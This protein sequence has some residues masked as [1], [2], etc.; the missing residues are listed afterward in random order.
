MLLCDACRPDVNQHYL[1]YACRANHTCASS[2][3]CVVDPAFDFDFAPTSN[4]TC[5]RRELYHS[6]SLA[7]ENAAAVS[8]GLDAPQIRHRYGCEICLHKSLF[9]LNQR[10]M[11]GGSLLLL[12]GALSG[13]VGI[14][15]GGLNIPV[16]VIVMG[17]HV[18]EVRR[19][20]EQAPREDAVRA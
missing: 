4:C 6:K 8:S 18:K 2:R 13:A 20:R 9:P 11:L 10:D 5:N 7:P 15:G 12:T 3:R 19:S 1:V 16:M 14:G 17:F